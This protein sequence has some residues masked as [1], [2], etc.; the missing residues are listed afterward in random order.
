MV[1]ES[2]FKA[3]FTDGRDLSDRVTLAAG[4][5]ESGL[6][7]AEVDALLA[8]DEGRDAVLA[9]ERK[10]RDLGIS[11][12]PFIVIS[13]AIAVSGAQAPE[14]F[15]AIEQAAPA[16]AGRCVRG[17]CGRGAGVLTVERSFLLP[18]PATAG[19]D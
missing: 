5:A 1:A 2:L 19:R 8:S 10:A 4:A 16:G 9:G 7:A 6:D 14:T 18:S 17:G 11:G 3:Y 12:V 13:E 15:Q